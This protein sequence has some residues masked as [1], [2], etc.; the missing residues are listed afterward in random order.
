M[1]ARRRSIL[2]VVVAVLA[3]VPAPVIG[4]QSG[5]LLSACHGLPQTVGFLVPGVLAIAGRPDNKAAR[6]LFALGLVTAAGFSVGAAWSAYAGPHPPSWGHTVVLLLQGLEL[7]S[8][9]LVLGLLAVFP[10]GSYQR[11]S[12]RILVLVGVGYVVTVLAV[13]NTASGTLSYPGAFVWSDEVTV[14]NPSAG[15]GLAALGR[16]AWIGYQAGFL[17]LVVTG[18]VLLV[19]RFRR[20]GAQERGQIMW[21]LLG[22][23]ATVVTIVVLA[24]LG[25]LV[26][27]RPDWVVYLLYTPAA[28][29]VPLAI[30]VGMLRHDLLGVDALVRRSVAY[31]TLWLLVTGSCV[32][33]A[34]VLGVAVGGRVPLAL[35]IGLAVAATLV[36]EPV[37]RRLERLSE[38]LVFGHQASASELIAGLGA[39]LETA[40]DLDDIP[41]T[42]AADVLAGVGARWVRV[43]LRGSGDPVVGTAG[44]VPEDG[45]A[46]LTVALVHGGEQV[47]EIACGPR[48]DRPYARADEQLLESLGRLAVLAVHN[49]HLADQLASRL[50]EL[51]ASRSRIVAAQ[52]EARRRL[53][54]DLHD[55]VQQE[56]V[57]LLARLGLAR[58]QLRRDATLAEETLGVALDDGRRTLLSLQETARGIHPPVLSDHGLA[59]AVAERTSRLPIRVDVETALDGCGRFTPEVEG[60][61]YFVVAEALGNVLKHSGADRAWVRLETTPDRALRVM[62]R[63]DGSGFDPGAVRPRG[64]VGLRDRVEAQG[65]TLAV[66][67]APGRGTCL[68]ATVAL[69]GLADG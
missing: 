43:E 28:M 49:A 61:A 56:L 3:T 47:G 41:G 50:A 53:E 55:G 45:A 34:L 42:V 44:D 9:A 52:D 64:L 40:A 65:G 13:E 37:R 58:N 62:V 17:L 29:A 46:A 15:F 4:W 12:E 27:D 36:A 6:R 67:S 68:T 54:Q 30:G 24:A 33:L 48:W 60:A 63:D 1:T 8:A 69:G 10:D 16:V 22:V 23:A 66:D 5:H 35:A 31:G 26:R 59:A 51:A 2:A 20:F 14:A 11:T 18:I 39:R 32:G 25:P 38:R 21:P 7:G 19:L 57:A